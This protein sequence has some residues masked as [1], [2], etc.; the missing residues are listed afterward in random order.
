MIEESKYCNKDIKNIIIKNLSGLNATLKI[1]KILL[2]V[3]SVTMI[4]L[5]KMFN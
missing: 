3:R 2:N 4:M 5:I 1:L